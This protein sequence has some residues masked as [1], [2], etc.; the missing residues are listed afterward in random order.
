[1]ASL[2]PLPSVIA[3]TSDESHPGLSYPE[4]LWGRWFHHV[5]HSLSAKP[6]TT[7]HAGVP[8]QDRGCGAVF[9]SGR[10]RMA[11]VG[12]P[13]PTHTV[14]RPYSVNSLRFPPKTD[15]PNRRFAP[16]G[17]PGRMATSQEIPRRPSALPRGGKTVRTRFGPGSRTRTARAERRVVASSGAMP[18]TA[19]TPRPA[20][21]AAAAGRASSSSATG[22][23]TAARSQTVPAAGKPTVTRTRTAGT[24]TTV[25]TTKT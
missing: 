1:M 8:L 9:P 20:P 12:A 11:Y 13:L 18:S 24:A 6:T 23:A 7:H 3:D 16:Q 5:H 10:P 14:L 25:S 4:L 17:A 21:P 22:T 19:P 15:K 2:H